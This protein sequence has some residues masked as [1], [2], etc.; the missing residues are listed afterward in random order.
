MSEKLA[1][2]LH[3]KSAFESNILQIEP[4][5]LVIRER[6]NRGDTY[7]FKEWQA[8]G[9]DAGSVCMEVEL[10]QEYELPAD[11]PYYGTHGW[12]A[13]TSG[14]P[15][16]TV[17]QSATLLIIRGFS[18]TPNVPPVANA[19][20]AQT[21]TEGDT[22]TLDG[23]GSTDSDGSIVSYVWTENDNEIATGVS[24]S[25]NLT[26]GIHTITLTVTDNDDATDA[27]SVTITVNAG[28][29][30][31]E[32]FELYAEGYAITNAAA[33]SASGSDRSTV[34]ATNYTYTA[35]TMPLSASAPATAHTQ[36][37][38][39]STEG[40]DLAISETVTNEPV[41]YIDQMAF[42]V[43]GD[44]VP[45]LDAST[46][47][48]FAVYLNSASNLVVY[49]GGSNGLA[50][51]HTAITSTTVLPETWVRL[52]ITADYA[53]GYESGSG[54]DWFKVE[55]DGVELSSPDGY[56]VPLTNGHTPPT[57]GPWFQAANEGV[58]SKQQFDRVSYTGTGMIDDLVV[59]TVKPTFGSTPNEPPELSNPSPDLNFSI[60]EGT[61]ITLSIVGVD[62]EEQPLSYT[63]KVNGQPQADE[64]NNSF[65]YMA[66]SAGATPAIVVT[67]SDGLNVSEPV[68]WNVTVT[69]PGVGVSRYMDIGTGADDDLGSPIY[70]INGPSRLCQHRDVV[71]IESE[72]TC[73]QRWHSS[74][75]D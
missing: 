34:I 46:S 56:A 54:F 62:P 12:R 13:D 49:H 57:D 2:L 22:V 47:T 7:T 16:V 75:R 63:W 44:D 59:T 28:P 10:D 32:T 73:R 41:V 70:N 29:P 50:K 8:A 40:D 26:V 30:T 1:G 48:Q 17:S 3:E 71:S 35:A 6:W 60:P 18:S 42:F 52:T 19:G 69:D 64:T 51:T 66:P 55:V 14:D 15:L 23:S 38:R 33:W 37:L 74:R 45:S 9:Q 53:S 58:A 27:D 65:I 21:V 61:S 25:V 43:P 20:T 5:D 36:V 24:P 68:T 4:E 39:L 72:L 11:S 67:A 31:P